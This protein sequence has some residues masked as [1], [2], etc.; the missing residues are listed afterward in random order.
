MGSIRIYPDRSHSE[1]KSK[2]ENAN[3]KNPP[4]PLLSALI[5]PA[6]ELSYGNPGERKRLRC[7]TKPN[8][9]SNPAI[10]AFES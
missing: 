7:E 3:S 9:N 5:R 6:I 1:I 4:G 10:Q 2:H 8:S